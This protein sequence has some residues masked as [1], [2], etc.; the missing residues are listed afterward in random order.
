[1]VCAVHVCLIISLQRP[2]MEITA[3]QI[4]GDSTGVPQLVQAL[5]L[6]NDGI[7]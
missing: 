2:R 6:M 1:M 4:T 7:P 5:H 3:S